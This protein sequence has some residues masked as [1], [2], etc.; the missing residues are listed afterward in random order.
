MGLQ[1]RLRLP[2]L[3]D[4]GFRDVLAGVLDPDAA[5]AAGALEVMG[6]RSLLADFTAT[7][8]VPY[9]DARLS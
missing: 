4:V 9:S 6:D 8:T 2:T 5:L 7:F 1:H 3:K